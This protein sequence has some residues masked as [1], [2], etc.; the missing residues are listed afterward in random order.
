MGFLNF[1]KPKKAQKSGLTQQDMPF[2]LPQPENSNEPEFYSELPNLPEAPETS[3]IPDIDLPPP[4][5]GF[6]DFSLPEAPAGMDQEPQAHDDDTKP[7][8]GPSPLLPNWPEPA[9]PAEGD[10]PELPKQPATGEGELTEEQPAWF[11]FQQSGWESKPVLQESE[12]EEHGKLISINNNFFMRAYDFRRV[13]DNLEYIIRTQKKHHR[14]TDI[15]K[16]ENAEYDKMNA[17]VEDIQRK[18]MQIDKTLFEETQ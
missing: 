10:L 12:T 17:L 3:A 13:K 8:G 16:D 7:V 15:K 1:L 9:K 4:M 18:L 11:S 14:L 5:K 2:S 6:K